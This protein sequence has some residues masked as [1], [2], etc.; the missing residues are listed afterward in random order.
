LFLFTSRRGL[1][2]AAV[3]LLTTITAC[4]RP[5]V[6]ATEAEGSPRMSMSDDL[7]TRAREIH[8]PA[9]FEPEK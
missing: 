6:D 9:G 8:W 2:P 3:F 7:A 1:S 5:D 4:V